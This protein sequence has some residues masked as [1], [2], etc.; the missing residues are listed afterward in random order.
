[1]LCRPHTSFGCCIVINIICTGCHSHLCHFVILQLNT[2]P[3]L[4]R[5]IRNMLSCLSYVLWGTKL[6]C[7]PLFPI[8]CTL[9]CIVCCCNLIW[10]NVFGIFLYVFLYLKFPFLQQRLL[11]CLA[12]WW[13]KMQHYSYKCIRMHHTLLSPYNEAL[14]WITQYYKY[15]HMYVTLLNTYNDDSW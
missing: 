4:W 2:L 11:L 13:F 3:V 5:L 6:L 8:Y 12:Q 7:L 15:I 9:C 1:M 10:T 14:W